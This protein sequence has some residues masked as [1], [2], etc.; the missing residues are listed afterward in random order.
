MPKH[1]SPAEKRRRVLRRRLVVEHLGDRRVL[2]SITGS[3]FNDVD[4]SFFR[5]ANEAPA[6]QRLVYLDGNDNNKLDVGERFVVAEPN[7]TFEI[8]GL[9]DGTYLLRLFNGAATQSQTTPIEAVVAPQP[10]SEGGSQLLVGRAGVV[11]M[12]QA[13]VAFA[14]LSTVDAATVPV[15]TELTKMQELPD[16]SILVIGTGVDGN[17]A[18]VIDSENKSV[19]PVDLSGSQQ[20]VNWS[21]IAIDGS[22]AGVLIEKA[23]GDVPIRSIDASNSKQIAVST[24]TTIVPADTQVISSATGHRSVVGWSDVGGMQVSLWSNSTATII[25][26]DPVDINEAHELLE[27]DDAAGLLVTRTFDGGVSVHDVNQQFAT[28]HTIPNARGPVAIDSARDLLMALSPLD[29]TLRIINL[30]DGDLIADLAVDLSSIGEA[31]ALTMADRPDAVVVLGAAGM[32]EVALNKPTANRVKVTGGQ[33]VDAVMFGV[34]VDTGNHAPQYLS[35][36]ILETAEDTPLVAPQPTALVGED[37][38]E[39]AI[40][41]DG[42]EFVLIQRGQPA[43]GQATLNIAGGINYRPNADFFGADTITVM[44][45]D[46]QSLTDNI[47]LTV[48]V[49]PV[50]DVPIGVDITPIPVPEN[51]PLGQ[52]VA[53]IDV[54]DVDLDDNHVIEVNDGRFDVVDGQI[55]FVQ[56][57]LDFEGEPVIS[58]AV[59]VSDP[60]TG[61]QF[62]HFVTVNVTD[63][64]DPITAIVLESGT[65]L[66]NVLGDLV[67]PIEVEDEDRG[68][69][70]QLTVDDSRFVIEDGILRLADDQSIN[71]EAEQEVILNITADDGAGSQLTQ[72]ITVAVLDVDEQPQ[73]ISLDDRTLMELENGAVVGTVSVDGAPA[74]PRLSLSVDDDRFEIVEQTLKLVDDQFVRRSDQDEIEVEITVQDSVGVLAA[75][76]QTF[77]LLVESNRTPY[78]NDENPYDVNRDDNVTSLDALIIINYLNVHGIG[79]VGHGNPDFGY[80][81]N[82][83]GFVTALDALLILNEIR[84]NQIIGAVGGEQISPLNSRELQVDLVVQDDDVISSS[85]TANKT[86]QTNWSTNQMPANESKGSAINEESKGHDGYVAGVDATLRL[87]S[88]NGD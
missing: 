74:N 31:V 2:A 58:L 1:S 73:E 70:H 62:T 20:Q 50:P 7:G 34:T 25:G 11:A 46:G 71:F 44:L 57:V 49:L 63:S 53:N 21:D 80:D 28:L 51:L 3:V 59:D 39:G 75:I 54:I 33:D 8:P 5:N 30:R 12:A 78:H 88:E 64:N 42:D 32:T 72:Q 38:N 41:V 84:R 48:N 43:N 47:Q 15:A 86:S 35:K 56:G 87:L 10:V 4:H 14:D 37:G 85:N 40:D 60:D 55:V 67:G 6:A 69:T 27:F 61:D 22:G 13:Q 76:S 65:I 17:S 29:A 26:E 23:N 79:P 19:T 77:V 52:P 82:G 36:P 81:V 9:S 66:E 16:G 18:W 68:Q 83:D 45:H 24:T